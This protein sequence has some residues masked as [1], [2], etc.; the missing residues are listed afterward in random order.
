[1]TRMQLFKEMYE[2]S[3]HNLLCYSQDYLMSKPKSGYV[4]QWKTENEKVKLLRE[5]ISEE[6]QKEEIKNNHEVEETEELE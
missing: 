2:L 1:M 4:K 6:K 3:C 5:L